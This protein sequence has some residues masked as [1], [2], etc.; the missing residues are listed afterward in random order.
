MAMTESLGKTLHQLQRRFGPGYGWRGWSDDRNE[1]IPTG[2]ISLDIALGGGIPR[3]RVTQI[4]G[5]PGAGKTTLA[6]HV[7]GE[8]RR[9][10]L[11]AAWI[12]AEDPPPAW[13]AGRCGV[14]P[15]EILT[16]HP[17]TLEQALETVEALART[18]EVGLVVVDSVAG[19]A[20]RCE[21][22]GEHGDAHPKVME[23]RWDQ[24]FRKIGP[25]LRRSK[26]AL[27]LVN[28]VRVDPG[29]LFGNPERRVAWEVLDYWSSIILDLRRTEAIR[30]GKATV[31]DRV[32]AVTRKN[33]LAPPL[34]VAEFV[35]RYGSGIDRLLCLVETGIWHGILEAEHGHIRFG[36]TRLSA[37]GRRGAVAFLRENPDLAAEI[38]QV[39]WEHCNLPPVSEVA[40]EVKEARPV[41]IKAPAL[42]VVKSAA[43][44]QSA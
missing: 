9:L 2:A 34:Q 28:Q 42:V 25:V 12:V 41:E 44:V 35:I 13:Y 19:L 20:P 6:L 40:R 7:A 43:V 16:F 23:R 24:A 11:T 39:I 31:G 17:L 5:P 22:E 27:V 21:V 4:F 29:V 30:E 14:D 18:G 37:T 26:T 10:G 33:R 3:G 38:E 36:D 1:V 15:L 32:K 8:A